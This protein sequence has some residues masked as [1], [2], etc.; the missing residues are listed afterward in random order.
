ML[1]NGTEYVD[2]GPN[3]FVKDSTRTANQLIRKLGRLGFDIPEVCD[4][5]T[6]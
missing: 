4:R 6:A 1:K 3:H 5:M 2:L